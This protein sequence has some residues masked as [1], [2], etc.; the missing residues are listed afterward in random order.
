MFGGDWM[1]WFTAFRK[2]SS[3]WKKSNHSDLGKGVLRPFPSFLYH[4]WSLSL[5]FL[6]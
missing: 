2:G 4:S 5:F 1:P 6:R 3:W